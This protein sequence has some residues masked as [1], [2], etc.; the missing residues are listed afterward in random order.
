MA[1]LA[2]CKGL[3]C[4]SSVFATLKHFLV[5]DII[6]KP[7]LFFYFDVK[8]GNAPRPVRINRMETHKFLS[9]SAGIISRAWDGTGGNLGKKIKTL[10]AYVVLKMKVRWTLKRRKKAVWL[11]IP[12]DVNEGFFVVFPPS[13]E[14]GRHVLQRF[15][16]VT[17]PWN[18]MEGK[19]LSRNIR[20][21]ESDVWKLV[22][23]GA[24]NW[25]SIILCA[26]LFMW[27]ARRD[28][29]CSMRFTIIGE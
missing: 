2:T 29:V 3:L 7:P 27:M 16:D 20:D 25:I 17:M 1:R 24:W 9:S 4:F 14:R 12:S 22:A 19:K 13:K 23:I 5:H 28:Y 21:V 15:T 18:S 8:L 26:L 10:G 6:A 11:T